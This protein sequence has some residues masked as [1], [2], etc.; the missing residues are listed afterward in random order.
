VAFA[1][2]ISHR[3]KIEER[4]KKLMIT[5]TAIR[6]VQNLQG[7]GMISVLKLNPA[8][9]VVDRAPL[10]LNQR[11]KPKEKKEKP[12]LALFDAVHN[13]NSLIYPRIINPR[14][15]VFDLLRVI[16]IVWVV[17]GHDLLYRLSISQNCIDSG[18]MDYSKNSWYFTY[19]Q[20]GFYAVDI[21][22][23]MG[24]Y[25]SII[26]LTRFIDNFAP[27]KLHKIPLLYLF[28]VFKRYMR[29]MPAYAVL[30]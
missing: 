19:N 5:R 29:I 25:V 30:I 8:A 6:K 20:S 28:C 23:F 26:S 24:G 17:L 15:Q 4:K 21:F 1:T 27:F 12:F 18:F 14:V 13:I 16:A 3:R 7:P 10:V 9:T 11:E 2:F 22:L